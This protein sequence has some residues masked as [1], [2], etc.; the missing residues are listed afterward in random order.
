M[1]KLLLALLLISCNLPKGEDGSN[2]LKGSDGINGEAGEDRY[3]MVN[4]ARPKINVKSSFLRVYYEGRPRVVC[5][6][7]GIELHSSL[8]G[9][10]RVIE[11]VEE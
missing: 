2:G 1:T 5:N 3:K 4:Y 10:I 9:E 8:S 11:A 7:E 6:G